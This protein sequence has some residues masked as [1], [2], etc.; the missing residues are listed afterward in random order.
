M[1]E[2]NSLQGQMIYC[3]KKDK[4]TFL[5]TGLKYCNWPLL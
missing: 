1:F 3:N 5:Q 4:M 2:C